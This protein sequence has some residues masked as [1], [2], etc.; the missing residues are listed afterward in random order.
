MSSLPDLPGGP[1]DVEFFFDPGCPF[2][3]QTAVWIRRVQDLRG[4]GVGWRFISLKFVN[5]GNELRPGQAEAQQRGLR[6]HRVC[7]AAREAHG[8]DAVG[9]LYR[10]WGE[11]FWYGSSTS[12]DLRERRHEAA[13]RTDPAEIVAS[14]GLPAS[15]RDA[16]DDDAWDEVIRA[17]TDEAL[18]RTGSELGTPIITYGPPDGMSLFGPVISAVP[19]D[20]Q[21]V[22][23]YD[24]IRVLTAYD[25]FA[26]L[27]RTNR[28]PLDLPIFAPAG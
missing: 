3:W 11:R 19:D 28:P 7:A 6:Y 27:K 26:E 25:G 15:L 24:A 12:D 9:D 1:Y 16:A 21:A 14:L 23:L 17:E 5:E 10:G 13:A 18:R 4:I 20:E 22:E 8:N 2:A